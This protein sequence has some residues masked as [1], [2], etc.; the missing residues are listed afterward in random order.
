M[1]DFLLDILCDDIEIGEEACFDVTVGNFDRIISIQFGLRWDFSVLR[2]NRIENLNTNLN[3]NTLNVIQA[4]PGQVN[5]VWIDNSTIGVDRPDNEILFTLCFTA[6]GSVGSSSGFEIVGT[7]PSSNFEFANAD[8][9]VLNVVDNDCISTI[10]G[11]SG[12]TVLPAQSCGPSGGS[13]TGEV[14]FEVFGVNGPFSYSYEEQSDPTGNNGTGTIDGAGGTLSLN[15]LPGTYNFIFFDSNNERIERV[16]IVPENIQVLNLSD[17][18]PRCPN[19]SNGQIAVNVVGGSQPY[20]YVWQNLDNVNFQGAGFLEDDTRFDLIPSLPPG[21]YLFTVVDNSGC[22]FDEL[23]VLLP[24]LE[25]DANVEIRDASCIDQANGEAC[26]IPATSNGSNSFVVE[27]FDSENNPVSSLVTNVNGRDKFFITN[28]FPGEYLVSIMDNDSNCSFDTILTIGAPDTI[29]IDADTLRGPTCQSPSDGFIEIDVSGGA[30]QNYTYRWSHNQTINSPRVEN[31]I[32]NTYTVT[33]TDG[34][35]CFNEASFT[36]SNPIPPRIESIDSVSIGCDTPDGGELTVNFTEGNS[37]IVSI[38]WLKTNTGEVVSNT[39]T[40]SNLSAGRYLITLIDELGCERRQF[41]NLASPTSLT[42]DSVSLR[43]PDCPG[44]E[45]GRITLNISGGVAP[46]EF[47]WD[48]PNGMNG[49]TLPAI[50]QGTYGVTVTDQE[51]CGQIIESIVLNDPPDIDIDFENI[52]PVSCFENVCDGSAT[53][54]FS[55]GI[56]PSGSYGIFWDNGDM[57]ATANNLCPGWHSV[58]I[59]NDICSKED[60]VFIPR[61]DS[62]HVLAEDVDLRNITCSDANDGSITIMASGGTGPYTYVWETTDVGPTISG[63][64]QGDYDVVITDSRM[65]ETTLS[66]SISNP[67][68]LFVDI[69]ELASFDASCNGSANGQLVAVAGG[70]S[71]ELTYTWTNNVAN[72]PIAA[73][74]DVGTYFV[75]VSDEN[76]CEVIDAG[77]VSEPPPLSVSIPQPP[78]PPCFGGLT[79]IQID[80][81]SGGNGGPY[82]FNINNGP[83]LPIDSVLNVLA[84]TY[85]IRVFDNRGCVVENFISITQPNQI[86]VSIDSVPE[87]QLGESVVLIGRPNLNVAIDSVAWTGVGDS[88][89]CVGTDDDCLAIEV[90]PFNTSTYQLTI[91]DINGCM[92]STQITVE[93]DKVRNVFVP[94]AFSPNGDGNNDEFRVY[95]GQGITNIKSIRVFDRWGALMFASFDQVPDP[96]GV[97]SWD[98]NYRGQMMMPGVYVYAVEVEFLDGQSLLYRGDITLVR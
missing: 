60:S 55:G 10:L 54:L 85:E 20:N 59:T 33:V 8:G 78:I 74:L 64:A 92:T 6:I 15:L 51:N 71:G 36:I 75:T 93:V 23:F 45:N 30:D 28:Q 84:S 70:G 49:P 95:T 1:D 86:S 37:P 16:V 81:V 76:G 44:F 18:L 91:W 83:L 34:S 2:L 67:D 82:R 63:L 40:A 35:G 42:L 61:P 22:Q 52:V 25:I 19:S 41:V 69:D 29:R 53:V 17:T 94:N 57:T 38:E 48:N 9:E 27:F 7:T 5:M 11:T 43:L 12:F 46:Y 26:V 62:I 47:T 65:C 4:G 32:A 98:G 13:A 72:G 79:T 90:S 68:S 80:S 58:I 87:I 50:G 14:S 39:A 31:L 66:F 21:R 97:I 24:N 56:D 3:L 96:S 88:I 89:L 77:F 73:Q